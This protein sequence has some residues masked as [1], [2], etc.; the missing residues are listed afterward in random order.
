MY[1]VDLLELAWFCVILSL[2]HGM[3]PSLGVLSQIQVL[4]TGDLQ[5]EQSAD[6]DVNDIVIRPFAPA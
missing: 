4:E 1:C 6:V 3:K 5:F 2:A